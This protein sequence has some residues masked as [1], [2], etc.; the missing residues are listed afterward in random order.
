MSIAGSA[1]VGA[2]P[3]MTTAAPEPHHPE[4]HAEHDHDHE[5]SG[6]T[7][8][9]PAT[10]IALDFDRF[11][12]DEYASV[13]GLAFALTGSWATAE[14]VTQ[15]AFFA[16]FRKW[17]Q[18]QRYDKPGAWV[19]RVVAN[20]AVSWRRRLGS[21]AKALTRLGGRRQGETADI[22]LPE[23][24]ELWA[25]VR[26]LP[27]RQAQ[28]FALTYVEDLSLEQVAAVL[29]ISAGTAKTHLK[30]ARAALITAPPADVSATDAIDSRTAAAQD[31]EDHA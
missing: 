16:A 1:K 20:R 30:R 5:E 15:D 26:R 14:D 22:E 28:V 10:A 3:D 24:A 2:G 29:A 12:A 8:E 4:L 11:C 13:A 21:E 6:P 18:L 25:L 19:R 9:L 31:E 17:E 7:A 23:D 27:P